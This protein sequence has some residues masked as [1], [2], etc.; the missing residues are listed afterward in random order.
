[1]TGETDGWEASLRELFARALVRDTLGLWVSFFFSVSARS[2]SCSDGYRQCSRHGASAWE[3]LVPGSL[4]TILEGLSA[5]CC[6]RRSCRFGDR[7]GS[8]FWRAHVCSE[9]AIDAAHSFFAYRKLK[10]VATDLHRREWVL[11]ERGANI[12]VCGC[13]AWLP[14][15]NP[16]DRRGLFGEGGSPRR[17]CEFFV[18]GTTDSSGLFTVL[19]SAR[20]GMVIAAAG[21]GWI[22]N[23]YPAARRLGSTN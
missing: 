12:P 13:H 14:D 10:W 6:G 21:L 17:A 9:F 19:D 22:H 4:S 2:I 15:E 11:G 3:P 20:F 1:V 7:A 8:W 23:Y 5:F 16:R 18:R